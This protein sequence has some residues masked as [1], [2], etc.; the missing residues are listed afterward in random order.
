MDDRAP[1]PNERSTIG[2]FF[3]GVSRST[4]FLALASLSAD[5]STELLYPV[6]PIF[7]TEV[8]KVGGGVVGLIEGTA[9]ATQNIVQGASGWISDRLRARKP[10]ALVGYAIAAAAK[11][12]IGLSAIWPSV[13]GARFLDRL[14]TGIRSSPRDALIAGSVS[15][16]NRGKAFGLEGFGDNFGAFIGPC[17]AVLLLG[18]FHISIRAIFFIAAIPGFVAVGFIALVREPPPSKGTRAKRER[19]V[20]QMPRAFWKYLLA[21][22]IFSLG[23]SSNSFLILQTRDAGA[24]LTQTILVYAGFNLI[25]ALTSYPAGSWS[26]RVGRRDL[27]A[28][29]LIIFGATYLGFGMTRNLAVLDA[30]FV[31][32]GLYQGVFRSVGK[33]LATDLV[34]TTWRATGVGWYS[35]TIGFSGFMASTVAG[36]LWQRVGHGVVFFVG[37]AG[38]AVGIVALLALVPESHRAP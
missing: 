36:Q 37:A 26:D 38:A 23:N 17:A 16:A 29:S 33:A 12:L 2:R 20:S 4:V 5:A 7:L 6:L 24:S 14:G 13:L 25:A 27:L 18:T 28:T 10:V 22:G 30:L 19:D 32:Y 8:L 15:D 34:P 3:S 35:A 21:I 11:P 9:E 1:A 31:L